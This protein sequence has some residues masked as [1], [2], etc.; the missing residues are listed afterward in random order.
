MKTVLVANPKGGSGKS[1]LAANLAGYWAWQGEQVMLGD[2]DRQHSARRWLALRPQRYPAIHGWDIADGEPLR[3]PKGTTAAV[4]DSPA[5]LHGKKLEAALKVCRRVLVPVQ[6]AAFDMWASED[7]FRQLA[8]EK[9]VRK[10]EVQI[11]IVAMRFNPRTQSARQLDSF[12]AGF[13]LPVLTHIR[14][15]QLYVQLQPRGLTLFDLPKP[16]Y[17]RDH[18]QWAPI[19]S[20]LK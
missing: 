13:G 3:P 7:F 8:E 16:R 11:G 6:A 20:W 5:G 10:G 18:A 17:E 15:T 12:L 4:L 1:T 14:E 2:L 9:V 19:L